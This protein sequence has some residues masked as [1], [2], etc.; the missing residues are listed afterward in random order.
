MILNSASSTA[1]NVDFISNEKIREWL[2]GDSTAKKIVTNILY[3]AG[4]K[5]A[6]G[7]LRSK[8][9]VQ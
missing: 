6:E 8:V 7:S 5:R 4:L 9:H 2:K 1:K 3:L